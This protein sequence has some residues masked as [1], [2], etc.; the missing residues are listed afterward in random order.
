VQFSRLSQLLI[1]T[2]I[3][4][5]GICINVLSYNRRILII[6]NIAFYFNFRTVI[7]TNISHATFRISGMK[8]RVFEQCHLAGYRTPVTTSQETY[9]V[10]ATE[11]SPLK[12]CKIL[13]SHCGDF[14][15]Y[16]LLECDAV[17]LL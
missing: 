11:P 2:E 7:Q 15:V 6:E 12:L 9:Y 3:S 8:E 17:W 5:D 16:R 4:G 10:S 1:P 14:E 13:G